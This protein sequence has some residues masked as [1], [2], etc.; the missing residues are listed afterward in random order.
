MIIDG[1]KIA[2]DIKEE[3]TQRV[4]TSTS[5]PALGIVLVGDD[6]ASKQFVGIKERM[7]RAIGIEVKKCV[8]PAE[9]TTEE[10]VLAVQRLADDPTIGGVVVQL[11][12]PKGID[13]TKVLDAIPVGKDVDV[14]GKRAVDSYERGELSI[15]PPVTGAIVE[16]IAREKVEVTGKNAVIIGRGALVGLPTAVWLERGGAHVTILGRGGDIKQHAKNA[17]ILV[18]GT[19]NAGLITPKMIKEGVLLFDAGA[20]ESSGAIVGDADPAC[21]TKCRIFTPVPRGIGPITVAVLM[22]NLLQLSSV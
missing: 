4:I 11:P 16:I 21:A 7:A 9:T 6:P 3:L 17:D 18:L 5:K 20:S 15:V 13:A 2:E 10:I 19:G 14:L 12:L 1:K 22:R 8:F